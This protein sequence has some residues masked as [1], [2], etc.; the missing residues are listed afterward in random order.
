LV[1]TIRITS[2]FYFRVDS[3]AYVQKTEAVAY[4]K[5]KNTSINQTSLAAWLRCGEIEAER[6]SAK[7]FDKEG[8]KSRLADIRKLTNNPDGFADTLQKICAEYGICVAYVPY[9]KNTNIN[10][11]TRWL[12]NKALIQ[13]NT[14]GAYSDIFWFTVFHEIGHVI[15]HGKKNVFLDF[16]FDSDDKKEEEANKFA[17]DILIDKAKYRDFCDKEDFSYKAIKE[18]AKAE[19]IDPSIVAGRLASA[20]KVSWKNINRLRHRIEVD[21]DN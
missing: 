18:F 9:F 1:V 12:K 19:E 20:G 10:G 2:L 5:S 4:R 8:I 7:T 16:S 11:A 3:L 13:L 17:A 15:L 14:R 6:I 21:L